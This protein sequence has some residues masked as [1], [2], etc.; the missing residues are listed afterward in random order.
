MQVRGASA[1]ALAALTG[2]LEERLQGGTD[3]ARVGGDLFGVSQLLRGEPG[4][5][6]IA[7][8]ASLEA[9]AKQDLVRQ[10]LT[11]KVDQV[12]LDLVASAVGRRWTA[13][14]DLADAVE[15]LS[16]VAAVRTSGDDSSRL[17]DEL[18]EVE[19]IVAQNPEL[20]DALADANRS[21]D[22]KAALVRSL[23]EGKALPAT[24]TL[25]QQSLA[26]TYRTVGAAL[27]SYQKVAAEVAGK[28]AATVRVAHALSAADRQRLADVLSAQ[29]GRAIHLNVVVDPSVVGGV[30]VEIGDDVI[31]GTVA[32]R[33]DD[34]RRKLVS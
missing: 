33:L 7:T 6:R 15:R 11:G 28:S 25:V 16:E 17:S 22:D 29:Y 12:A 20:R 23:L 10:V 32:G 13:S 8:D 18:F 4:L 21:T 24:V 2:E 19:Q 1:D 14:R 27:H 34:A 5:R 26:G 3:S 9:G 31:D 30:R